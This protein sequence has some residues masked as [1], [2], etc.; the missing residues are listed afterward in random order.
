MAIK[1]IIAALA[2][3]NRVRH[4]DI[5]GQMNMFSLDYVFFLFGLPY[6]MKLP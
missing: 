1:S 5:D 3:V 6:S 4:S 2:P